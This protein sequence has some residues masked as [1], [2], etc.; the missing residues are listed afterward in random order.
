MQCSSLDLPER[1]LRI[2]QG[3]G[4]RLHPRHVGVESGEL[5]L[6]V[7]FVFVLQ[8]ARVEGAERGADPGGGLVST[9]SSSSTHGFQKTFISRRTWGSSPLALFLRILSLS[10][11]HLLSPFL[12]L[13]R[14]IITWTSTWHPQVL[15]LPFQGTHTCGPCPHR[16]LSS[17]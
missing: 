6:G 9:V 15:V 11:I 10:L 4:H 1:D 16:T 13:S 5:E 12:T 8:L 17:P 7:G 2:P 3:G 14:G